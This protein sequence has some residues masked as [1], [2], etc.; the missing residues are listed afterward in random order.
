MLQAMT[1]TRKATLSIFHTCQTHQMVR[2]CFC[3]MAKSNTLPTLVFQERIRSTTLLQTQ[4]VYLQK[5]ATDAVND[6][7]GVV[8]GEA[9]EIDV[10]A[11]DTDPEGDDFD[12]TAVTQ[13]ANGT[14][15]I[16][17][18]GNVQYTPNAGFSG[19]DSFTYT[20]TDENGATDTATVYGRC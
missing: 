7:A 4:K 12:V 15:T 19:D 6:N 11:N 17:A 20:I 1:L 18:N 16:L 14:V 3:Q 2:L 5:R 10:R 13:G 9:T 8:F